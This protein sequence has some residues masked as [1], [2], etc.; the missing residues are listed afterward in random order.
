MCNF[1]DLETWYSNHVSSSRS[2]V[3]AGDLLGNVNK[4]IVSATI[5]GMKH[6]HLLHVCNKRNPKAA[7]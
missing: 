2:E 1:L 7:Q 3:F 5:N 4:T 6:G